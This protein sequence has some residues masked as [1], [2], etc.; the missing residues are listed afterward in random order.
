MFSHDPTAHSAVFKKAIR[1]RQQR[2]REIYAGYY[3]TP[4]GGLFVPSRMIELPESEDVEAVF[5]GVTRGLFYK[6]VERLMPQE[7]PVRSVFLQ[8]RHATPVSERLFKLARGALALGNEF[9]FKPLMREDNPHDGFWLYLV[10]NA[11]IVA[12][13]TGDSANLQFPPAR[14]AYGHPV[15]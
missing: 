7:V 2:P 13:F 5:R 3:K 10:F 6:L 4:G 15:P 14:L 8:E 11:G 1:S 12:S 9:S